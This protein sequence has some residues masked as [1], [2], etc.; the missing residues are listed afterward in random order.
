MKTE[1]NKDVFVRGKDTDGIDIVCP[2]GVMEDPV[3]ANQEGFDDCFEADVIGRYAGR[4]KIVDPA[5]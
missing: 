4:I 1:Q 5:A 3:S 2:I